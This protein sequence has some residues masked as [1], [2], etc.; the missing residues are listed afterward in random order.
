MNCQKLK[1][2]K[3]VIQQNMSTLIIIQ[4]LRVYSNLTYEIIIMARER[5]TSQRFY[6]Y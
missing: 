2:P 5:M 1:F 6:I 3:F 4:I